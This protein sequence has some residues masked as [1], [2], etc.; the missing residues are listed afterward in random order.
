MAVTKCGATEKVNLVGGVTIGIN[1]NRRAMLMFKSKTA[2]PDEVINVTT[3]FKHSNFP[4][5][6]N[7]AKKQH[8]II[9][10]DQNRVGAN[11]QR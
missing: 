7:E 10:T 11:A 4:T 2:T 9:N 3:T 5:V 6:P 1:R 8:G